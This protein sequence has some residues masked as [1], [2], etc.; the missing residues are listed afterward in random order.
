MD[1]KIVIRPMEEKDLIQVLEIEKASFSRPWTLQD[2][3]GSLRAPNIYMVAVL[4]DEIAGYCGLWG[5][6]GE[7]QINNVA[8]AKKFRNQGIGYKMLT[9]LINIG[10]EQG[11]LEFT[12]EVRRSNLSA[13]NVYHKLGFSEE[14]IRKNYYEEPT[15]DGIIMWLR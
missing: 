5:V 15:E 7:G 10:R 12:L 1:N 3:A 9:H 11:L 2:F 13:I 8:V 4:D 14:G 6:L